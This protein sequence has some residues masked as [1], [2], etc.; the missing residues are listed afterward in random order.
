MTEVLL[1]PLSRYIAY[2]V[3]WDRLSPQEATASFYRELGAQS[4]D[5]CDSDG[6]SRVRL[7]GIAKRRRVSGTAVVRSSSTT[8][9][10][11]GRSQATSSRG[12]VDDELSDGGLPA[13]FTT[14]NTKKDMSRLAGL[15]QQRQE[16]QQQQRPS[17][18]R[19][20]Q[21]SPPPTE[22][23]H[24]AQLRARTD[25]TKEVKLMIERT[26]GRR[27]DYETLRRRAKQIP[28]EHLSLLAED[29]DDI[30]KV[31]ED[32]VIKP[33]QDLDSV[34]PKLPLNEVGAK[35]VA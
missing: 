24:V 7:R 26:S 18:P 19:D 2:R 5:E 29:P 10:A 30:L 34:M 11:T 17:S 8:S 15:Q 14:P 12:A 3:F 23:R 25:L 9:H 27:S 13:K 16:E 20:A 35:Q 1:L 32:N 31:F 21:G 6:E 28:A 33:L 22:N 4:N